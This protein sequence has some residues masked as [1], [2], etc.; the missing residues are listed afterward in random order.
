MA[1]AVA[2]APKT[3]GNVVSNILAKLQLTDRGQAAIVARQA[4]LGLSD[5]R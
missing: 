1:S 4:G 2:L 5:E 3:V